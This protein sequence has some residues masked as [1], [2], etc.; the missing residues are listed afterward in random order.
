MKVFGLASAFFLHGVEFQLLSVVAFEFYL[1]YS[2]DCTHSI[3]IDWSSFSW[4]I[5]GW[6][7]ALALVERFF[8]S[9][10]DWSRFIS[11]IDWSNSDVALI[12][13]ISAALLIDLVSSVALTGQIS[14]VAL[15]DQISAVELID[16][17]SSVA[18]I[19][20]FF[21]CCID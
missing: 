14:A 18:L 13:R 16:R 5:N 15:T 2:I 3:S 11:C 4:W 19:E 12:G 6:I 8:S 10:I 9:C 1:L 21:S 7:S 20:R 17:I